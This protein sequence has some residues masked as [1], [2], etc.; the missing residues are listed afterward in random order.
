MTQVNIFEAKSNLSK[1]IALLESGREERIVIARHGRPVANL[2]Y[3][4]E[5]PISKRIGIAED[6][7]L[8]NGDLDAYNDEIASL[9][10]S[11]GNV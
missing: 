2:T 9:F 3:F 6:K 11:G 10:L 1:L 8:C 5:K 7:A 4:R